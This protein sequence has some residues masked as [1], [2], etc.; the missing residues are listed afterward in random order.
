M[1]GA[2]KN[3]YGYGDTAISA[4]GIIYMIMF[5]ILNYPS[6]LIINKFG[7]RLAVIIGMSFTIL[8]MLVKL[9]VNQSFVLVFIG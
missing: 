1:V 2:I 5:L 9:L 4:L 7:L 8:G 3:G 6:S